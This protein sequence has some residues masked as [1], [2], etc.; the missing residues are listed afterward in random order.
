MPCVA[1]CPTLFVPLSGRSVFAP[2]RPD[3]LSSMS[4]FAPYTSNHSNR[5][6]FGRR[7]WCRSLLIS[8]CSTVLCTTV[9]P[10]NEVVQSSSEND[11]A[12]FYCV[13]DHLRNPGTESKGRV[14][15]T[16]DVRHGDV[17]RRQSDDP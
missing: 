1:P 3:D 17:D 6:A 8:G 11:S 2:S 10:S 9:V 7:R 12:K 14:R 4:S 15:P 5:H 16:R 13:N